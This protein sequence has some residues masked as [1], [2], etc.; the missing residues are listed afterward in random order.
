[1]SKIPSSM[2]FTVCRTWER[3][4][5]VVTRTLLDFIRLALVAELSRAVQQRIVDMAAIAGIHG[6]AQQYSGGYQLASLWYDALRDGLVA[7]GQ[8]S[9]AQRLTA[10]DVR[11]VFFGDLFR[12]RGAMAAHDPPYTSADVQTGLERDLLNEFY[13]ATVA[14]DPSLGPP[15]EVMGPG[16]VAAQVMVERMLRARAFAGIAERALVGDL[17]QV[18]RFLSCASI[19]E[20]VLKRVQAEISDDTRVLIGHSLGS[21][22]A[23]EYLYQCRPTSVEL[24]V[25]LGS[26]LGIPNLIFDRLTPTP[27]DGKGAWPGG[28]AGW[29]N[30][31]DPNDVVALRKD[32]AE[33]FSG[34]PP[35]VKVDDRLVDNGD[36]PHAVN[37]YLGAKQ[38]GSALGAALA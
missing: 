38:T 4:G 26:P 15:E 12:P 29:V 36:Q 23:Y 18:T 20:R 7:A 9:A 28:V 24:L 32:L 1:M 19:K 14:Q 33:L 25:T 5:A 30:V 11:V 35:N 34:S 37:R 13:R 10:S 2:S 31:A 27:T 8:Q 3:L 16:R 22:V 17:K 21:V 6:I